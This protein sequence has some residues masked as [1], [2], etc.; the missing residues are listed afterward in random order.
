MNV[1]LTPFNYLYGSIT[2]TTLV[3]SVDTLLS[4]IGLSFSETEDENINS[5]DNFIKILIGLY[6]IYFIISF[7]FKTFRESIN[8]LILLII[9]TFILRSFFIYI[10]IDYKPKNI[11]NNDSKNII[12]QIILKDFNLY[13]EEYLNKK[14]ELNMNNMRNDF[15]IKI[16]KNDIVRFINEDDVRHSVTFFDNRIPNTPILKQGDSFM[17]RFKDKGEYQFKTIYT[18]VNSSGTIIVE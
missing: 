4:Y 5:I 8:H 9:G 6:I 7:R 2:N 12:H 10:L 15:M 11:E 3:K 16:K 1:I 14:S 17:I 18:E 13:K